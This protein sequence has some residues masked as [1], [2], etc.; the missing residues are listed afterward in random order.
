MK[1]SPDSGVLPSR[2]LI[3]GGHETGGLNSFAH[4]LADGFAETGLAAEVVSPPALGSR[5]RDLRNPRV[6]KI[7]SS[8]AIFAAPLCRRAICVAHGYPG[9]GAI[10]WRRFLGHII[11]DRLALRCSGTKLVTVSHYSA[12][13]FDVIFNLRVDAVIHNPVRREFL[14]PPEHADGSRNLIAFAGRLHP[15]KN[16]RELM[17]PILRVLD[18]DPKLEACFIGGGPLRAALEGLAAGHPR[19]AFPGVLSAAALRDRLR[20]TRVFISG[21]AVE[22]LGITYLEALS[23]GCNV[24]MPACGGGLELAPERIGNQIQLI[25][26][27]FDPSAVVAALRRAIAVQGSPMDVEAWSPRA[28]ASA[29][30]RVGGWFACP[31]SAPVEEHPA[32]ASVC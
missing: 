4:A 5:L 31:E 8:S 11:A 24:V 19:V 10:G 29:Y 27:T 6:L 25:P 12:L 26:L 18:E 13:H 23:Q 7:L 15:C 17:P 14:V 20:H 3:T 21:C 2:V 16:L 32:H 1:S 9:A 30:L 22:A 28:I